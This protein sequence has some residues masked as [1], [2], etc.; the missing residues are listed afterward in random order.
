MKDFNRKASEYKVIRWTNV[1]ML[2]L[3]WFIESGLATVEG[4]RPNALAVFVSFWVA[5][6]FARKWY[7][8]GD[9]KNQDGLV[10]FGIT[11]GLW[12]ATYVAKVILL[13]I[14]LI[15]IG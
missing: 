6:Y 5:R 15:A 7:L 13:A 12:I 4:A 11:V 9:N 8:K 3:L 14:L 1:G 2:W 10:K